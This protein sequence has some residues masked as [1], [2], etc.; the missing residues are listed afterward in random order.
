MI[1]EALKPFVIKP[2]LQVDEKMF[3][4]I[5]WLMN[6]NF[7]LNIF[8]E[9]SFL[10]HLERRNMFRS[11]CPRLIMV[12]NRFSAGYKKYFFVFSVWGK[13]YYQASFHFDLN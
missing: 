7:F 4:Q 13:G 9:H 10:E 5:L 12:G 3:Q 1:L 2:E 8:E 6:F 11:N